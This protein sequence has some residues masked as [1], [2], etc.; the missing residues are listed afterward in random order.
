MF[1]FR[2]KKSVRERLF[3][4]ILSRHAA[5]HI[6][7]LNVGTPYYDAWLEAV[8]EPSKMREHERNGTIRLAR[9]DEEKARLAALFLGCVNL[10]LIHELGEAKTCD[11]ILEAV[12]ADVH[13]LLAYLSL[14]EPI[15]LAEQRTK[16]TFEIYRNVSTW[17]FAKDVE[18]HCDLIEKLISRIDD[19]SGSKKR[20]LAELIDYCGF[21]T[22][23]VAE[24]YGYVRGLAR[25][26]K[27]N[28]A[29]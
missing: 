19:V 20:L 4:G 12:F 16:R 9:T 27:V 7:R 6:I 28:I 5:S 8:F 24:F 26:Y 11:F 22:S 17:Q 21:K 23:I 10:G 2:T 15:G 13:G 29:P 14:D 18:S 3:E 25:G 1:R